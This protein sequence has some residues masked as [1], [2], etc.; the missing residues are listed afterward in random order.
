M[1]LSLVLL[2]SGCATAPRPVAVPAP[3]SAAQPA[4][5]VPPIT[6]VLFGYI[7]DAANDGFASLKNTLTHYFAAVSPVPV[8]ITINPNLNLYDFSAGGELSTLLGN[9][10]GAVNVVEIDTLLMGTLVANGW[11]QP[12]NIQV[13]GILG[14]ATQAAS[15]GGQAYGVPTYL[16]SNVIYSYN[17]GLTGVGNG[18][19]LLTFLTELSSKPPLVGNYAGSWTLPGSYLDAWA[20]TQGTPGLEGA[21]LPP[22]N[23]LTMSSF[24]PLVK[25]CSPAAANPCLDGTYANGTGTGAETAF[26]TGQAN[27][28]VGYTERLFYIL[29]T[30]PQQRPSLISAPLGAGSNPVMFVDALVVNPNCTGTCLI[31]ATAFIQYMSQI[32]TRNLIAFSQDAPA[33]TVPRYLLQAN[34][35]FYAGSLAQQD[36]YYPKFWSFLQN[37]VPFPNQGFPL[38]RLLLG[39]DVKLALGVGAT[40]TDQHH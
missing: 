3:P 30:N 6:A 15:I 38:K 34:G 10:P 28:F 25:S 7:P 18:A 11:V 33:G 31:N 22:V 23:A 26:A 17:S 37:A 8:E 32:S 40:A 2:W 35:D 21:Y 36:P 14:P 27:G 9:G 29:T 1:T 39:P 16:C 24:R 20:D 5:A 19:D 12:L 4:P 13:P